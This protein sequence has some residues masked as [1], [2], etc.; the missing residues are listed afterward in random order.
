MF[1]L[2]GIPVTVPTGPTP[3]PSQYLNDAAYVYFDKPSDYYDSGS[4][5]LGQP[6]VCQFCYTKRVMAI[7]QNS[8][9][10]FD[11]S[12]FGGCAGSADASVNWGPIEMGQITS[13][14]E[15]DPTYTLVVTSFYDG[16]WE[17]GLQTYTG[18]N[19]NDIHLGSENASFAFEGINNDPTPK[20]S[21]TPLPTPSPQP[22]HICHCCNLPVNATN[23]ERKAAN[24]P[25]NAVNPTP[26]P[27]P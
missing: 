12:C 3:P 26:M 11:G 19:T 10:T 8:E 13:L 7:A 23:A 5:A 25:L 15:T 18:T 27:T 22:S 2:T 9:L 21:P 17:G 16:S 20:P 4:D 1:L 24:C 14:S 6:T